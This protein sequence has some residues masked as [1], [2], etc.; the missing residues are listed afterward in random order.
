LGYEVIE[1][2]VYVIANKVIVIFIPA[3]ICQPGTFNF[4]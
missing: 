3:I 4:E 2:E 1:A